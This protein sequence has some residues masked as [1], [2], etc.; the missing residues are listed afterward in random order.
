[1]RPFF[2][3]LMQDARRRLKQASRTALTA[4]PRVLMALGEPSDCMLEGKAGRKARM[5]ARKERAA[6]N[7]LNKR[8]L[9]KK[10]AAMRAEASSLGFRIDEAGASKNK[11]FCKGR[12]QTL[13]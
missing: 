7:R 2:D 11:M 13:L 5:A 8:I 3:P 6:Q 4:A 9:I 10:A 12:P 1:M